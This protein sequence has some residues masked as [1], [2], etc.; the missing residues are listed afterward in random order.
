MSPA[1]IDVIAPWSQHIFKDELEKC[2]SPVGSH[3]DTASVREFQ[4]QT[5]SSGQQQ[6]RVTSA[7]SQHHKHAHL[8]Q[9]E[10]EVFA[11]FFPTHSAVDSSTS[12]EAELAHDRNG[13]TAGPSE[14][15]TD[16]EEVFLLLNFTDRVCTCPVP[17]S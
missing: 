16:A 9:N 13:A 1:L 4:T 12:V 15:E 3:E 10:V 7:E 6:H 17:G 5:S 2:Q 11:P 8:K 14:P